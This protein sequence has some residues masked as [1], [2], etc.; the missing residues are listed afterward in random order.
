MTVLL[1][2]TMFALILLADYLVSRTHVPV[3]TTH[4]TEAAPQPR[5]RPSIVGGF[6]LAE[7]VRYH[8]GHTW[9]LSE[10]PELVR[11]GM[12]DFA[13]RI[14]GHLDTL[15]VPLTGTWVRQG[16]SVLA[17][18]RDGKTA[19]LVSPIEGT[20][21]AVNPALKTDP[22]LARR[23]PYGEG[24]LFTVH[25]PDAKTNFRNLLS[26]SVA[27]KWM[28]ETAKKL[29]AMM[30]PAM[31]GALAQDGGLAVDDLTPHLTKDWE[32]ATKEFFLT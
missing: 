12:D 26:G 5:L 32:A 16:Q 24:W 4:A 3:A 22:D 21:V 13:A 30:P 25:A 9:A 10:S 11:V 20:V 1:V 2:V 8:Q 17:V 7:N 6:N 18:Q 15:S 27:R 23:D 29:Q 28:E 31:A 19:T 14:V